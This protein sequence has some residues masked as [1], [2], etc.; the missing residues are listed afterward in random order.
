LAK[1]IRFGQIWFDLGESVGENQ[2]L[3]SPATFD[4]LQLWT[5]VICK[6]VRIFKLYLV[7]RR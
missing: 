2:N 1:L 3:A 6:L 4:L 5:V 7:G